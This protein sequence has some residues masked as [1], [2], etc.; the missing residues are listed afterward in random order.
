MPES[1]RY[2]LKQIGTTPESQESE[3]AFTVLISARLGQQEP[4]CRTSMRDA[5]V[6]ARNQLASE[7]EN[8]AAPPLAIRERH[9]DL[10]GQQGLFLVQAPP[11]PPVPAQWR[12]VHTSHILRGYPWRTLAAATVS[13][14]VLTG[15]ALL[16]YAGSGNGV[17][18]QTPSVPRGTSEDAQE[19][20]HYRAPVPVVA[21]VTIPY[22]ATSKAAFADERKEPKAVEPA[23][24]EA[25][26]A[27]AFGTAMSEPLIGAPKKSAGVRIAS[28]EMP[29]AKPS[30]ITAP[31][32]PLYDEWKELLTGQPGSVANPPAPASSTMAEPENTSPAQAPAPRAIGTLSKATEDVLLE[33]ASNQ[34]SLGDISGARMIYEML[35]M[36]GSERGAFGLAETYDASFLREHGV[37]GMAPDG[38]LARQWYGKA[39]ALGSKKAAQRLKDLNGAG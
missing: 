23:R 10:I 18:R 35:A 16:N 25:P 17:A 37:I 9:Q 20:P 14:A 36:Q 15:Y 31:S 4:P 2:I 8:K 39:A 22:A 32:G 30:A 12:R 13:G 7:L 38:L 1:Q 21:A 26:P 5:F 34:M 11:A 28:L 6:D 33:R 27:T 3:R 19:P 24:F 29:S